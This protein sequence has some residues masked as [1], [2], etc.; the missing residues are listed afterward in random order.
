MSKLLYLILF[1]MLVSVFLL[2]LFFPLSLPAVTILSHL[3]PISSFLSPSSFS[4]LPFSFSIGRH[5]DT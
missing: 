4:Y 2:Y 5:V 1:S 3:F